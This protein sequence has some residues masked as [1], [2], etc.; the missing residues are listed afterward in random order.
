MAI[1]GHHV[2]SWLQGNALVDARPRGYVEMGDGF[3][4]G[5]ASHLTLSVAMSMVKTG[6]MRNSASCSP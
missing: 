4:S 2:Q 5:Q 3:L 1:Y 6:H